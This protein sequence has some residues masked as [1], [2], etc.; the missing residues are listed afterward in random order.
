MVY[1][2]MLFGGVAWGVLFESITAAPQRGFYIIPAVMMAALCAWSPFR[3][4]VENICLSAAYGIT[5]FV[6]ISFALT[7]GD[8]PSLLFFVHGG[9]F[10]VLSELFFYGI[11][12]KILPPYRY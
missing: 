2:I 12:R 6:I 5:M 4:V 10:V 8:A 3:L 1:Y 11:S 7:R 9:A